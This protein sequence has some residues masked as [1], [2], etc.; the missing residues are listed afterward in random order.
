MTSSFVLPILT[1]NSS[2][3]VSRASSFCIKRIIDEIAVR[4]GVAI[5][6]DKI[7]KMLKEVMGS[8]QTIDSITLVEAKDFLGIL[9]RAIKEKD[10]YYSRI[11]EL[12]E[13]TILLRGKKFTCKYCKSVL[14]FPLD[15]L[16]NEVKCYCCG[17]TINIPI[18]SGKDIL[19][20][21]FKLNELLSNAIDQG[22]LPLMLTANFL[23]NQK[24]Y[25]IRFIFDIEIFSNG[26]N[27]AE[28]D[29]IFTLAH[30]IGM[31]EVKTNSGFSKDQIDRYVNV[32]RL[33][34]AELLLFA[35]LKDRDSQE[36]VDLIEYLK[37]LNL[38]IPALILTR[39]VLFKKE[40]PDISPYFF[41]DSS[42]EGFRNGPI[43]IDG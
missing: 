33:L 24:I 42:N 35:T 8:L 20:D 40:V 19:N 22:V 4:L 13:K 1:R 15:S 38:K 37:S 27:I 21:S 6:D 18:F 34:N 12:Y 23:F 36:I 5:Q 25:G 17:N 3:A 7:E 2:I 31:A 10:T 43:L 32:S 30:K 26:T 16:K 11:Q 41:R 29:I 9:N 14:W 28:I 39:E